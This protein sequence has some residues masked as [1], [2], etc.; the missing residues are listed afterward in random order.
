MDCMYVIVKN[1][2]FAIIDI[3]FFIYSSQGIPIK[4]LR[5]GAHTKGYEEAEFSCRPVGILYIQKLIYTR[6]PFS[7]ENTLA[8][9]NTY[10]PS[11]MPIVCAIKEWIVG[12]C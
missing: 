4:Y 6:S 7:P 8:Y 3:I 12:V 9:I 10:I 2:N 11:R 1:A 5:C